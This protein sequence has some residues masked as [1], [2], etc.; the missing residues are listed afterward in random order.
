MSTKYQVHVAE[1]PPRF[2]PVA[3][4]NAMETE[5]CLGCR[6]CVKRSACVY[7]VYRKKEFNPSQVVD[8]TDVLCI[9]CMR[10]VQECKKNILARTRNPQYD[11]LGD[12]YWRPDLIA[13]IWQQAQNGKIPVSGAGYR[14]PFC[15]PGFD[16]MWT[17]MSEIVRPTRDGIHGREYIS[18]VIELGRK[19]GYLEFSPDGSMKTDVPLFA[20]IPIPVV[21]RAPRV[22]FVKKGAKESIASAAGKLGTFAGMPFADAVNG[23]KGHRDHLMVE[24]DPACDD[25]QQLHGFGLVEIPYGD[26]WQESI[27][28]I[29]AVDSNIIVS[30]RIPLDENASKRAVALAEDGV[31]MLHLE[32]DRNGNGLGQNRGRFIIELVQA[33][34]FAL[35]KKSLR[36]EITVLVSG[37]MAMAEHVAKI[38][39]CGADGAVLDTVLL[40]AFECRLCGDCDDRA[41][42]PVDIDD[43]PV[44]F[45]AQRLVNLVG[46][47]HSQLIEVMGAMGLREVR[48]LRGEL[49]RV[50]FFADLEK[51]NFGPVFGERKR[52]LDETLEGAFEQTTPSA[53]QD[54]GQPTHTFARVSGSRASNPLTRGQI[55]VCPTR[56]RNSL[57]I[58]KVVRTS[59]CLA[60]GKCAEIC[61]YGVFVKAGKVMLAP[62]SHLCRGFDVCRGTEHFCLNHCPTD[63]I[64]IGLDPLWH[65]FGDPRWT[66]DLLGATWK[67]AET[68]YPPEEKIE[69]KVG[70]SGGGFDRIRLKFPEGE[71]PE[72]EGPEGEGPTEFAP[73][74]VD[75]SVPL[76]RRTDDGRP[77]V[78]IGI[79]MYGGG[80]SFGSISLD[81][82]LARA[83]AFA[84]FDSFTCT[85]EGGYP[86]ALEPYSDY[87]ITQVATGLFG[88]REETIQ[89]TR[90]VEFKYAQGAKPGL[91]GHLLGDKNTPAVA[92]MREAVQGFPLFSP[93]PFHSVYSVEDHKKHVDWVK[94]I[95]PR[96]L[97]AV[98][99]SGASDVDMVAVGSYY[100]GAHIVHLDG[101]YGGTGAAPDIAKKNIAM[102]IEYAVPKVH[103]FLIEEGVRDEITLAASGGIRTAWDLVKMIALG[104]DVIVIGTVEMVALECIR[105]GACESGRGCPRGIATTDPELAAMYSQD[106]AT[107]RLV[108]LFHAWAVQIQ[109]ILW[110][111]G[112]KNVKELVGR[113]DLLEHLDYLEGQV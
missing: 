113:F 34:H 97:V 55:K 43:V 59:D 56:F 26:S 47:W 35:L 98:K 40:V 78:T 39:A 17:D 67:Q 28:A 57:G 44:E 8:T 72:G 86:D 103:Q 111:L 87:V 92:R 96:A 80:M 99:V 2:V 58:Y 109:H 11:L 29:K 68:G 12:S 63:A 7:D 75:L 84:M 32:A 107:Q 81:T 51:D 82:I 88:V 50:M 94:E 19:P 70:R 3:E 21:L 74:D 79:P 69:Y 83:R 112:M 10:C 20:E 76:N 93:F 66:A 54:I 24:F 23:L 65:A 110:R 77:D 102:P 6:I 48:R 5:G 104:A 30:V 14:G 33:A 41:R 64:R 4:L 105:C 100:A 106:W 49:G 52:S 46:A 90:I 91:G 31:E 95:N 38:I 25:A 16:S 53:A 9:S 73:E 71:G 36:D 42:C 62:R 1:T 22:D 85:G 37:G 89:R 18:T 45:G 60:C 27:T 13:S 15:G 108:N 101:S 61:P